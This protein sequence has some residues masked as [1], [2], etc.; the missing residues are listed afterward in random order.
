M[1]HPSTVSACLQYWR[2]EVQ[3]PDVGKMQ[4]ELEKSK[5]SWTDHEVVGG[6]KYEYEA[7]GPTYKQTYPYN[8][9]YAYMRDYR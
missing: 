3:Q 8:S 7:K 1:D 9:T 5:R 4:K 6:V 2:A